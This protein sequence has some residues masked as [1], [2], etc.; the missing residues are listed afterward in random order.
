MAAFQKYPLLY[1]AISYRDTYFFNFF[2]NIG[3][4][5]NFPRVLM[6]SIYSKSLYLFNTN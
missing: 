2:L 3:P 6:F 1:V 5:I 4:L